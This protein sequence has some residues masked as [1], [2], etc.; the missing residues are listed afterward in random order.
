MMGQTIEERGGH[1]RVA[2]HT[3]PIAKGQI[4][5]TTRCGF[6]VSSR[7]SRRSTSMPTPSCHTS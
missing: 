7:P 1:L 5:R 6:G 4:A 3:G 2:K